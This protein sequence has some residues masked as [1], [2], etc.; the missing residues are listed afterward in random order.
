MIQHEWRI[1]RADA[2][3]KA[4]GYTPVV[5]AKSAEAVE[6]QGDELPRTA[7]E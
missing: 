2:R 3:G 4:E 1:A 6:K 7:K 5:F